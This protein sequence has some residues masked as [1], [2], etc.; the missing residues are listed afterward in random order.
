M[1]FITIKKQTEIRFSMGKSKITPEGQL[2]SHP[3]WA[4]NTI[5][6]DAHIIQKLGIKTPKRN[7]MYAAAY[8]KA[9]KKEFWFSTKERFA[10]WK[11]VTTNTAEYVIKFI[12]EPEEDLL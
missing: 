10:K 3:K 12:N 11:D 7:K 5:T 8:H 1:L 6:S 4:G 9:S 2:V